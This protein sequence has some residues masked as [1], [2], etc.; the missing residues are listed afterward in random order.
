MSVRRLARTR[1]FHRVSPEGC[2]ETPSPPQWRNG[3]C[4][5]PVGA[6]GEPALPRLPSC[7]FAVA[8][9]FSGGDGVS[10]ALP[11]VLDGPVERDHLG[12]LE[13]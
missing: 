5:R 13:A 2:A 11:E 7:L 8:I 3:A 1:R 9:G 10:H 12:D 6:R 4:S